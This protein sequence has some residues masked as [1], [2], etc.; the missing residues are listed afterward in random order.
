MSRQHEGFAL[1]SSDTDAPALPGLLPEWPASWY[2]FCASREL[3]HKPLA[4]KALGRELVAFRTP[5]GRVGVLLGQC[6]H[7]GARLAEGQVVG[8]CLRCP[9]HHWEFDS[10]GRCWRIPAADDIPLF[11]RQPAFP[12]L[13]RHGAVFFF[14]GAQ[15]AFALPFF[16]GCGETDLATA[17][18]FT[19]VLD[20]PWY[21]IGANGVDVQHFRTTHDRELLGLPRI[22]HPERW[23]HHAVTRFRVAGHGWRDGLTRRLAGDTVEMNVTD[24]AGTLFFVRAGFRRT[25]TFGM[26][27]ML[28]V[29]GGRTLLYVH[30]STRRSRSLAGRLLCDAINARVRRFFVRKFL[31]PDIARSVGTRFHPHR[32]IAAD[33]CLADYFAWLEKLHGAAAL[34][35]VDSG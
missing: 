26:V 28:P 33:Q 15:P 25:Q 32:L 16:E 23:V 7:M 27:S 4:R 17:A 24:W 30:V 6:V 3:G 21:M 20:C 10:D 22:T 13:E 1:E 34:H 5:G 14:N 18:P 31:E 19:L 9:F 8:E 2:V 35:M 12:A 29:D 11:A